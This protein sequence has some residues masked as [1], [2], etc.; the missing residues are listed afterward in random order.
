MDTFTLLGPLRP[1]L[2]WPAREDQR[3]KDAL[4]FDDFLTANEQYIHQKLRKGH[5]DPHWATMLAEV[6]QDVA[7]QKME[8]DP[9]HGPN[10]W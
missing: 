10:K 6:A 3:Y 7:E 4:S 8:T 5:A 1:G 9:Q 2:G